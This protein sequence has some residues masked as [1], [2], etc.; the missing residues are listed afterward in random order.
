MDD[1]I[2][3]NVVKSWRD[4]ERHLQ[5]KLHLDVER[6]IPR[7]RRDIAS[8]CVNDPAN[9][10][11]PEMIL[12]VHSGFLSLLDHRIARHFYEQGERIGKLAAHFFQHRSCGLYG[13]DIHPG[14]TVGHGVVLDHAHGVVIG[15]TAVVGDESYILGGVILGAPRI[16]ANEA[17][18]RHPKLGKKCEIGYGV[19]VLGPIDIGDRVFV[20][21]YAIVKESVPDDTKITIVSQLTRTRLRHPPRDPSIYPPNACSQSVN[22]Q[23]VNDGGARCKPLK[24]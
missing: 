5:M 8:Y 1:L 22:K 6:L 4:A 7:I 21:P 23:D 20:A 19:R 3:N 11:D 18:R 2:I 12:R 13:V 9:G 10:N 17:G 15:E 14:A 24:Q 16:R